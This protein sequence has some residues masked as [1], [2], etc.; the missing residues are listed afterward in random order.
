MTLILTAKTAI[1]DGT[2]FLHNL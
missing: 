2:I 1:A